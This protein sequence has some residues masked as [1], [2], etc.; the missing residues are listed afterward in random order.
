MISQK[1]IHLIETHARELSQS[2]LKE[3]RRDPET[4][5]YH[6]F[7][8][9]KLTE[10]VDRVYSH[11]GRFIECEANR[12]EIERTYTTLGIERH[13]EG[14]RLS[15]VLRALMLTKKQLWLFM[16][17][18]GFFDSVVELYQTLELYNSVV[19]FFDRAVFFTARGYEEES[20]R[21]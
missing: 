16:L 4:P 15:E 3:V 8:E 1:L 12:E 20:T 19:V 17:D 21:A 11:L 6:A 13:R 7:P 2:W 18:H 5:T 9:A 14:F 10:R